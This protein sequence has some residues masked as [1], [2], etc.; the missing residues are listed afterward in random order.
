MTNEEVEFLKLDLFS[1][2]D[3]ANWLS[4]RL[5][6]AED[7]V[8]EANRI[9]YQ[10]FRHLLQGIS[11]AI[12]I[13]VFR[14]VNRGDHVITLGQRSILKKFNISLVSSCIYPIGSHC[15]Y[16]EIA[17]TKDLAI[18]IQGGG[19]FGDVEH[20]KWIEEEIENFPRNQRIIFFPNSL[21]SREGVDFLNDFLSKYSDVHVML[22]DK[23]SYDV[24][25]TFQIPTP[26]PPFQ[27]SHP[28][29]L[30]FFIPF[31]YKQIVK[32][33]MTKIPNIYL[34]PDI[35]FAM[36]SLKFPVVPTYDMVWLKR[37]DWETLVDKDHVT[38]LPNSTR[39]LSVLISD[40]TQN[41]TEAKI[42]QLAVRK[43]KDFLN[44]SEIFA[45]NA[46]EFLSQGKIVIT[47]R[48]HAHLMSILLTKPSVVVNS[49]TL[50]QKHYH[51]TWL[52]SI[53]TSVFV[54]SVDEAFKI[55]R[56]LLN[57]NNK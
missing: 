49:K 21:S 47:D 37:K 52:K 15:R 8:L 7:V 57:N 14:W 11:R 16:D 24:S 13:N 54:E 22:R 3:K 46:F 48:L 25:F 12:F 36:G 39:D 34:S 10:L 44:T 33:Q 55:G 51:E 17:K 43:W 56:T 31:I 53:K 6:Y 4:E 1:H 5:I 19:Y 50:K 30:C 38:S 29:R 32:E 9:H 40:W 35:A 28:L 27:P 18:F 42:L 41:S 23:F 2:R 26:L 45:L 20:A